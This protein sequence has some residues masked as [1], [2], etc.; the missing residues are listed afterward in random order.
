[1]AEIIKPR[2][3]WFVKNVTNQTL[4]ITDLPKIPSFKPGDRVDVLIYAS[5]YSLTYSVAF[6][7]YV[8]GKYDTRHNGIC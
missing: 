8:C 1:M 6:N 3:T 4:I 7:N 2:E 5:S